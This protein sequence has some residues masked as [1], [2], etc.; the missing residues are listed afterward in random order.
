MRVHAMVMLIAKLDMQCMVY[1]WRCGYHLKWVWCWG[2]GE[3]DTQHP[4]ELT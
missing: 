4:R 2:G 3:V 1:V